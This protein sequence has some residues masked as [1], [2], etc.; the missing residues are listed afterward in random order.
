VSAEAF[1]WSKVKVRQVYPPVE[2]PDTSSLPR[3]VAKT[4][5]KAKRFAQ[6]PLTWSAIVAK[7]ADMPKFHV[8]VVL[9]HKAWK[10]KGRPFTF[11]NADLKEAGVTRWMKNRVLRDLEDA[12][13]IAVRW[14]ATRSPIVTLQLPL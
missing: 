4:S 11:G 10:A 13:V 8:L 2:T 1:D 9:A 7:A 3:Q 6:I 5:G 12:G 14:S